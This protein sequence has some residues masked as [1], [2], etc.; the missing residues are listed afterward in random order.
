VQF[1]VGADGIDSLRG[2]RA[3]PAGRK[4]HVFKSPTTADAL[5]GVIDAIGLAARSFGLMFEVLCYSASGSLLA[6]DL[7]PAGM[8]PAR[9]YRTRVRP[10]R[11]VTGIAHNAFRVGQQATEC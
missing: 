10:D 7:E 9:R 11:W 6:I 4:T 8:A 3:S 1:L 2:P 5:V